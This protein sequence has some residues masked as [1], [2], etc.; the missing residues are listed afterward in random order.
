MRIACYLLIAVILSTC[1]LSGTFAKYSTTLTSNTSTTTVASWSF[2]VNDVDVTKETVTFELFNTVTN[3]DGSAETNLRLTDGKMIA[4][5]TTGSFSIKLQNKSEVTAMYDIEFNTIKTAASEN[6]PIVF[7]RDGQ[8]W[9]SDLPNVNAGINTILYMGS[10]YVEE[11]FYWKWDYTGEND[12]V[13]TALGKAVVNGE[14]VSVI[15]TATVT[16]SQVD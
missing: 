4:P 2:N 3:I 1:A 15:L 9:S 13:D 6:L 16:A 10:D 8:N 5:G 7:S 12:S 14:D 11:K